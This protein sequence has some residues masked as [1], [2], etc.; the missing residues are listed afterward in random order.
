MRVVVTG[1]SGHLGEGLVRTL[2]RRGTE[3]EGLD[4]R[5][6]PMTSQLGSITDRALVRRVLAGAD[7]V[8]HTATLHKP[9]VV[10]HSRQAFVETNVLGTLNLLEEAAAAKARR[11]VFTST[12][13]VF[14]RALVP[15]PGEPAAWITEA[16]R[17][18]PKNIY[19]ATKLAAEQLCQLVHEE[20]A[21]PCLIL[22][23]S[24]FFPEEDDRRAVREAYA[25]ENVKANEYLYRRVDLEDVVDAHLAALR[26]AR[27]IGFGRYVVSATTPFTRDQLGD[28]RADAAGVVA[29][30][31]PD[32]E[33]T[34]GR[35]GWCMFPGIDRVYDNAKA[36]SE[37]GW[38]PRIDFGEVLARLNRNQDVRSA[39]AREVGAKGYHD[40]AFDDGPYPVRE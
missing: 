22:R 23:T 30:L 17:P 21:L 14:G 34:Y 9:H 38:K 13:S 16:V 8:V 11:F 36:R 6:G 26:R 3:V 10:T 1:S 12:T 33:D 7:S 20:H 5:S 39:L 2:R 32:F 35:L 37:L 31:F 18:E 25:D 27:E 40:R 4:A 29:G 15:P 24:R 19:G 28:V